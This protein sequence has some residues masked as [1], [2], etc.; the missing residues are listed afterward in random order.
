MTLRR[1]I[2]NESRSAVG[3][4]RQ[5]RDTRRHRRCRILSQLAYAFNLD[6]AGFAHQRVRII[7]IGVE[8][9]GREIRLVGYEAI[10][11]PSCVVAAVS[12]RVV[13]PGPKWGQFPA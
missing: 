8:A 13:N 1:M 11:A 7:W 3:I 6:Q 10:Q 2:V 12:E 5:V 4:N 9:F